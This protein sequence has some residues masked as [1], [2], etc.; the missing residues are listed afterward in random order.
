M[1]KNVR[2]KRPNDGYEIWMV[3]DPD[4]VEVNLELPS[5]VFVLENKENLKDLD[6]D[7]PRTDSINSDNRPQ[8]RTSPR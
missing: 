5:T 4:T 7:Q 1:A 2:I 6:L 8:A 3:L